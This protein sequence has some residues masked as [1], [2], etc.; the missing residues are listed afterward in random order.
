MAAAVL[1]VDDDP[2]VR[3]MLE[4]LLH[5]QGFAPVTAPNGRLALEYL[6]M[7]GVADVILLDLAMP[8]MDGREF[9]IEQ[10]RDER[11][12]AIPVVVMSSKEPAG[13]LHE[14]AWLPK[15]LDLPRLMHT[16]RSICGMA[17]TI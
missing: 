17:P 11:L 3:K 9:R 7:G 15:P 12:R 14:A 1:I 5:V 10:E 2:I 4:R 16:L 6:R 8:V 13:D